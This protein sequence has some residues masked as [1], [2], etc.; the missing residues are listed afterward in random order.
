[1]QAVSLYYQLKLFYTCSACLSADSARS[2]ATRRWHREVRRVGAYIR[3]VPSC[4]R[5]DVSTPKD[6]PDLRV[7]AA[8]GAVML[9]H[10]EILFIF[11]LT[12]AVLLF[13]CLLLI[14][15]PSAAVELV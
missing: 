5:S 3:F 13:V 15:L 7:A 8:R 1:M 2:S 11:I 10:E 14:E 6:S 4:C 12:G 9:H